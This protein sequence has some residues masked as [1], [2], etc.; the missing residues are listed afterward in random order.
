MIVCAGRTE[1]FEFAKPI[2]VGL[3]ESAYNLSQILREEKPSSVLFVGSCGSYGE[4]EIL[5]SF[6]GSSATQVE[7]SAVLDMAYTPIENKIIK[8]V[9]HETIVNS[10]NYITTDKNVSAKFLDIGLSAENMEFYSVLWAAREVGIDA[11]GFFVVTNHCFEDAR[12]EYVKNIKMATEI[13]YDRY[14]K[15]LKEYE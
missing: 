15:E 6:F 7:Q 11:K 4:L 5:S 2:G 13:I 12:Q 10:S 8:N 9:S 3:I 1:A 14:K